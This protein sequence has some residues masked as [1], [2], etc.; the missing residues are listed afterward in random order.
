ML[1]ALRE[2]VLI[3]RTWKPDL[4]VC[5][6]IKPNLL[7]LLAARRLG[8]PVISVARGW[9]RECLRVRLYEALDRRVLRWMDKVV[10]V[11][12][13]QAAKVRRAGVREDKVAVIRNAVRPERFD[14]PDPAYRGQLLRMFDAKKWAAGSG[15]WSGGGK[16]EEMGTG[17]A[18]ARA[19][20]AELTP[21]EVPVP[22]SSQPL[23]GQRSAV[24]GQSSEVRGEGSEPQLI[25][26]AAGR[27]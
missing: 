15:Q 25:V 24:S 21:G 19:N 20:P 23:S 1:A 22:I 14:H 11:S 6:N 26:G 27:S 17:S 18:P 7:G 9:T 8:I 16:G 12:E 10:C 5:H 4:L 2:L 3:L 13:G